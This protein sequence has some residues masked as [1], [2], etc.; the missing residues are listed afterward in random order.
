MEWMDNMPTVT[1]IQN[2][3]MVSALFCTCTGMFNEFITCEVV[4]DQEVSIAHD[5]DTGSSRRRDCIVLVT[6]EGETECKR[7]TR[8]EWM[9]KIKTWE[10][11]VEQAH[12]NAR[13]RR[14]T[15]G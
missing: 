13:E 11:G 14:P 9:D 5:M 3:S 1:A 4:G 15:E 12:R 6:I 7:Q 2:K 10:G 8:M